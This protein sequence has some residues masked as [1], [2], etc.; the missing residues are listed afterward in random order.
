MLDKWYH[1]Y[2]LEFLILGRNTADS[3]SAQVQVY[4]NQFN[5]ISLKVK[6][7]TF[8]F[9]STLEDLD[10]FSWMASLIDWRLLV[11]TDTIFLKLPN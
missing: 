8:F 2:Y 10:F 1:S 11:N 7:K 3:S 5:F 9:F 4:T 6:K